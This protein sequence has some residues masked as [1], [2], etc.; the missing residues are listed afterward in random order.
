[1][2]LLKPSSLYARSTNL[3]LDHPSHQPS[4]FSR[5]HLVHYLSLSA[6]YSLRFSSTKNSLSSVGWAAGCVSCVA[7]AF[8]RL[9]PLSQAPIPYPISFIQLGSVIIALNGNHSVVIP[10]AVSRLT[11]HLSLQRYLRSQGSVSR[12]N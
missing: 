3:R 6:L 10:L 1:M 2:H 11:M 5:L 12:S 7:K 8:V 4:P 9:T